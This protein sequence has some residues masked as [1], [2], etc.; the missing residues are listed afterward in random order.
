[1]SKNSLKNVLSHS[2][3]NKNA[4]ELLLKTRQNTSKPIDI[5]VVANR[6][7][8]N[9]FMANFDEDIRGMVVHDNNE[10]SIYINKNDSVEQKKFA[11]ARGISHILLHEDENEKYFVDYR[12]KDTYSKKEY[13]LD[14]FAT[15]LLMPKEFA[16][17]TWQKTQKIKDFAEI[18]KVS[19]GVAAIRLTELNL[20]D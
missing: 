10:Y 17:K 13:E 5:V 7:G 3:I 1:M 11:I 9:A 8:Y 18:M 2:L 16:Y 12:N 15:A 20:I 19:Q 14:S 4:N 6:L